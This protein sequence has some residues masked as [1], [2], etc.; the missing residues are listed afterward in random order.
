[1]MKKKTEE[2]D[3]QRQKN[4]DIGKHVAKTLD[5]K[6]KENKQLTDLVND[7]RRQIANRHHTLDKA[8]QMTAMSTMTSPSKHT[9][10]LTQGSMTERT[11]N[12]NMN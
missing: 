9:M 10:N 12:Y 7:L 3:M 11:G 4:Q 2:L 5:I 8:I 1:M 6:E